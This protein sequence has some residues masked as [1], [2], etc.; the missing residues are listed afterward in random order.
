M[1]TGYDSEGQASARGVEV[2]L[3]GIL[4]TNDQ[5]HVISNSSGIGDAR[6]MIE[7]AGLQLH[8]NRGGF[9][10]SSPVLSLVWAQSAIDQVNNDAAKAVMPA[11]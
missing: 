6:T 3:E 1:P 8:D 5:F 2:K 11:D 10:R 4:Q 7:L 9:G